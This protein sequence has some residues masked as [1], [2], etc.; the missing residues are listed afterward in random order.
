MPKSKTIQR[1]VKCKC[2]AKLR[3]TA[4][5]QVEEVKEAGWYFGRAGIRCKECVQ[6]VKE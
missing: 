6:N 2:G 5:R 1:V 3:V 4:S